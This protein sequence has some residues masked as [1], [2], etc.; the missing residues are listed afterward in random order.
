[1]VLACTSAEPP[2][3]G[4][5]IE[6]AAPAVPAPAYVPVALAPAALPRPRPAVAKPACTDAAEVVVRAGLGAVE[7]VEFSPD[8]RHLL[9]GEGPVE[10][11][12][13]DHGERVATLPGVVATFAG[14]GSLLVGRSDGVDRLAWPSRELLRTYRDAAALRPDAGLL[15]GQGDTVIVQTREGDAVVWSGDTA[16]PRC[17][18]RSPTTYMQ[19]VQAIAGT[20]EVIACTGDNGGQSLTRWDTRSC[21]VVVS[22]AI[23]KDSCSSLAVSPRGD[24]AALGTAG[25]SVVVWDLRAMRAVRSEPPLT[26]SGVDALAYSRDG[27]LLAALRGNPVEPTLWDAGDGAKLA[28]MKHEYHWLAS[29]LAFSPDGG[30]VAV[31]FGSSL[32]G[33]SGCRDE[34]GAL[35]ENLQLWAPGQPEASRGLGRG[36]GRPAVRGLAP[37][38]RS[39]LVY[40]KVHGYALMDMATG[41]PIGRDVRGVYNP[42]GDRVIAEGDDVITKMTLWD[43]HTGKQLAPIQPLAPVRNFHFSADG[44]RML[45]AHASGLRQVWDIQEV[46]LVQ[47]IR[48]LADRGDPDEVGS[49]A[50]SPDGRR[51]LLIDKGEA[52]G[53]WD[54]DRGELLARLEGTTER[55]GEAPFSGDGARVLTQSDDGARVF[56]ATSGRRVLAIAG[57]SSGLLASDGAR[58]LGQVAGELFVI[59]VETGLESQRLVSGSVTEFGFWSATEVWTWS[60]GGGERIWD[61]SLGTS[62]ASGLGQQRGR[63]GG[64]R[65]VVGNGVGFELR[66]GGG[67]LLGTRMVTYEGWWTAWTPDGRVDASRD[68]PEVLIAVDGLEVCAGK[69]SQRTPGLWRKLL[70]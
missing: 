4:R 40:D 30:T 49:A 36:E 65:W 42:T 6:A 48:A 46:R 43:A 27:S 41:A 52:P 13:V 70:R 24:L 55:V 2:P 32:V 9:V 31:G 35:I 17:R 1:M 29:G 59:D 54:V 34:P 45:T 51:A 23:G 44:T 28:A 21:E 37:D 33:C 57:L 62:R 20:A 7:R 68:A 22:A 14:D 15:A 47:T 12:S 38:G 63:L 3:S 10:V 60:Y 53:V 16:A 61:L 25:G 64:D 66:D 58:V 67:K 19:Y 8:G 69:R 56:D 39:Y 5:A 11:W 50:L 18:L 26:E